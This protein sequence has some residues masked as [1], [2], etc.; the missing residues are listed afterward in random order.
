MTKEHYI[1]VIDSSDYAGWAGTE[2]VIWLKTY[3]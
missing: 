2:A 3:I 1:S